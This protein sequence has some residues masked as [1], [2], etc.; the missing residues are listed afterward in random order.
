MPATNIQS[1][2]HA[3]AGTSAAAKS[4][5]PIIKPLS[6]MMRRSPYLSTATPASAVVRAEPPVSAPKIKPIC[7][8]LAA[9]ATVKNGASAPTPCCTIDAPA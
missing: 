2:N 4:A 6:K 1:S 3:Y 7:A 9:K 8:P 5:Q